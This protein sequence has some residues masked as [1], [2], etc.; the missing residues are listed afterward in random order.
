MEHAFRIHESERATTETIK[1]WIRE[2]DGTIL[3]VRETDATRAHFQG[4]IRSPIKINTLRARIKKEFGACGNASYSVSKVKDTKLYLR[5]LLKGT[6]ESAPDVLY[7]TGLEMTPEKMQELHTEYWTVSR[8]TKKGSKSLV[9]EAFEFA[10]MTEGVTSLT[11]AQY[12]VSRCIQRKKPFDTFQLRRIKNVVMAARDE[13]YK[14][15]LVMD[16]AQ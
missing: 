13:R 4:Y 10:E 12:L 2:Q 14:E 6:K 8:E 7:S 5:Y 15:M 1:K 16:I 11:L 9:E 3:V